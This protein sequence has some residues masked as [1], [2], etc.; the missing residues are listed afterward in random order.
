LIEP[1]FAGV[2]R[3]C[4]DS[5]AISFFRWYDTPVL[6]IPSSHRLHRIPGDE[7]TLLGTPANP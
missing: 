6:P 5:P 7:I 2:F 3:G 4:R 1:Q